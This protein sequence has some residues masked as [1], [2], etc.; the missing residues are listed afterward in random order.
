M[1]G[2]LGALAV[3]T[4][5]LAAACGGDDDATSTATLPPTTTIDI[6]LAGD[7]CADEPDLADYPERGVP[8]AVRPCEVPTDDVVRS[9][10]REGN[11]PAS[12]VGDGVIYHATVIRSEDGELVDSSWGDG[13]PHNLQSVGTGDEVPGV[14]DSLVGVHTGDVLRLDVPADAA[15]GETPPTELPTV[16]AG[17]ALTFV[18][19]VLAVVPDLKSEDAPL[20]IQVEPSTDATEVTVEDIIVG[21]GKV[22]EEGDTVVIAL[23]LARGDNEV[24]L[25]NSWH[26]ESPLIVPLDPALMTGP[27]PATIPGVF[28][29]LQGARVGGRRV[30]TMPPSEAFGDGGQPSLGLPPDTDVIV[31][32]DILAAY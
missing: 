2:P 30:I 20:D 12:E 26:Q 17:D 15:F 25:V 23:L 28:E 19:E 21:D 6:P 22:V 1:R 27:E 4:C 7:R 24:V 16:R 31:V 14:D 10:I 11:G 3:I 32:A 5:L 18:I 29:G 9:V 8:T 13:R